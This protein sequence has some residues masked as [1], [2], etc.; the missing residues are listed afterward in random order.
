MTIAHDPLHGS[1]R[2][3]LPHPALASGDD[4][5]AG[6]RIGM[7]GSRH[8]QPAVEKASHTIPPDAAV[9]AAPRQRAMAEPPHVEPKQP[10][11]RLI[12]GHS[13]IAD[14]ATNHRLQP[15]ALFGNGCVQ[16]PLPLGF[17][18]VQLR[19][20]PLADRLP[21]YRIHSVAS[22]LYADVRKAEKVE[23]LRFPFSTLLMTRGRCGSLFHIRMTFAFTTPRRFSR[24]TR[25]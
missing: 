5:H 24:R 3:E 25:R 9:L 21:Q 23:R 4:A 22:L 18:R 17:H 20:Q 10:Q 12:H 16:A 7:A 19:L 11:R 6:E 1:G 14:M 2:V 15:F 13:V 8:R